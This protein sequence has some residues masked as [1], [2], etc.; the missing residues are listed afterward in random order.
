MQTLLHAWFY[1]VMIFFII[2]LDSSNLYLR[3]GMAHHRWQHRVQ[4]FLHLHPQLLLPRIDQDEADADADARCTY[5][6]LVGSSVV[7][8]RGLCI[9]IMYLVS[10]RRKTQGG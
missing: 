2:P 6:W 3:A 4:L 10:T 7:E 9:A 5:C 1:I 8:E